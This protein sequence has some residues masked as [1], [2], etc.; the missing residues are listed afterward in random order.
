T[1]DSH[2]FRQLH[3][4]LS[5]VAIYPFSGAKRLELTGGVQSISFD[6]ETTT[7]V[8]S[9]TTGQLL[10]SS[11]LTSMTAPSA[12][13]FETGAALVYDTAVFGPTSPILGERYRFA[14][15]PTFGTLAF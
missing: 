5:G 1:Q 10:N 3:R 2:V 13:L 8:Y 14:V 12:T 15:S 9:G 11:A 6:R 7:S 4:D